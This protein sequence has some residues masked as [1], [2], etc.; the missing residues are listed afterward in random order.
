[1]TYQNG[2]TWC[3]GATEE[4]TAS[5]ANEAAI[6]RLADEARH[7]YASIPDIRRHEDDDT[8]EPEFDTDEEYEEYRKR[9]LHDRQAAFGQLEAI[10]QLM[11]ARGARFRRPYEHW[12]E[13]ERQVEYAERDRYEDGY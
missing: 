3:D 11:A 8:P 12:N 5:A 6:E 2:W 10:E 1:M 13:E 9:L 7:L 4:Q